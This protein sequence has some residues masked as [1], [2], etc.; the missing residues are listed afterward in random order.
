MGEPRQRPPFPIVKGLYG[1]PT[2]INNVET[3]ANIPIIVA[4]GS[5]QYAETGAEGNTGT[6]IFSLVGKIRNTGLVEVPMGMTLNQV[7]RHRR[8]SAGREDQGRTDRRPTGGCI[9]HRVRPA[10][11]VREPQGRGLHVGSGG[12]IVM[13][14]STHDRWA[15][16]SWPS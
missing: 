11:H 14:D 3:W 10:H 9:R 7:V 13:D 4:Q 12:M 16:V 6:K 15:N 1:R 8:R 2:M 5:R